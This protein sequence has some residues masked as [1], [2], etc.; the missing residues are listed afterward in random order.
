MDRVVFRAEASGRWRVAAAA[1]A[2]WIVAAL[3]LLPALFVEGH[4]HDAQNWH[5]LTWCDHFDT[6]PRCQGLVPRPPEREAWV[7]YR[8]YTLAALPTA[9]PYR[10][11]EP[12][13]SATNRAFLAHFDR[14]P[15]VTRKGWPA[16]EHVATAQAEYDTYLRARERL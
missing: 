5:R 12:I 3:L 1:V 14:T 6:E 4:W 2:P 9:Y 11:D 10:P 8:S 16:P 7:R 13:D 15:Y